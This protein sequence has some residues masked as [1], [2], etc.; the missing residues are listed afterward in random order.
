LTLA[1]FFNSTSTIGKLFLRVEIS[2]G[3]LLEVVMASISAPNERRSLTIS[4][5]LSL[6]AKCIGAH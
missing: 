5:F 4:R 3:V 6:Q 2:K 1:P